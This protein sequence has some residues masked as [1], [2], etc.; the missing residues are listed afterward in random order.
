M[1]LAIGTRLGPYE[2]VSVIGAGGMGEVYCAEDTRLGRT[3]AIK[4]L[5]DAHLER[6]EL[7]ARAIA[8]LNHPNI[9]ALYD[10]GPDYLV[11]ERIEGVPLFG[12]LPPEDVTRFALQIAMALE[13][14]HE[15]GIVH[16][17]LKPDNIL[18][19][20]T[21]VKL[22]D[23]GLAKVGPAFTG[24]QDET[25]HTAS[26]TIVGTAAYMSPEQAEGKT[27]DAR[28]D[29]FSFGLVL[30]EMLSGREAFARDNPLATL[31]AILYAEPDP[32]E[33]PPELQQIIARCLRKSPGDRFQTMAEVRAA[34]ENPK[35]VAPAPVVDKTPSI[36]VLPFANMSGDQDNEYFSDGLSEEIISAL[37][38]VNGLKVIA[39]SSAFSFKGKNQDIRRIAD[40]L[41][42]ANILEGSV[43]RSGP[44]VRITAQLINAVDGSQLWS[45][46]FDR[47]MT[48]IFAIQDEISQAIVDVLKVKLVRQTDHSAPNI[49]AYQAYLEGRYFAQQLTAASMARCRERYERAIELDPTYALPHAG[50]AEYHYNRAMYLNA[51]P[52]EVMAEALVEAER[53][54]QLD[55]AA[56]EGYVMR[57]LVRAAY[58]Y[59][60]EAAG[61]D[62]T[63]AIELNPALAIAYNRRAIWCLRPL[64]RLTEA[65][66]DMRQALELDPLSLTLRV[67]EVSLLHLMGKSVEAVARARSAI[68]M[69]P[70]FWLASFVC[71]SVFNAQG[72]YAEAETVIKQGLDIDPGNVNLLASLCMTYGRSGRSSEARKILAKLAELSSKQYVSP[73]AFC[74]ACAGCH[75][76]DSSFDCL[77][78]AIDAREPMA[79]VIFR[80]PLLPEIQSHPRYKSLLEKMNLAS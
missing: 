16:R 6:F 75:D 18:V 74:I 63:R 10:I 42:V 62:F 64:G 80:N 73:S 55:P 31:A 46:R 27:V 70:E 7:E 2:I 38:H 20:S 4:M 8:S 57:G 11:M 33:A 65:L 28:S 52:L 49:E 71:S 14:A 67:G 60:W 37:T 47:Q 44:R 21:G 54:L 48:D 43:R 29:I 56:A 13:A 77:N 25:R 17:D 30:Y 24:A 69:F 34:L 36:A 61:E 15:K 79:V 9:C 72:L 19:T 78:R 26:G 35:L 1:P 50:L 51:P 41:G 23:F 76:Y 59:N 3:V 66:A 45:E 40:A 53:A 68:Q 22:L 12:P 32:L 5:H 39:R 58:Q